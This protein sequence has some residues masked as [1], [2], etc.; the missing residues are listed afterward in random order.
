MEY[1]H[2]QCICKFYSN[3]GQIASSSYLGIVE[4]Q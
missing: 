2:V 3:G 4:L 1:I